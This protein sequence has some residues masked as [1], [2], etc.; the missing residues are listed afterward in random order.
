MTMRSVAELIHLNQLWEHTRRVG[1]TLKIHR[2]QPI[3][4]GIDDKFVVSVHDTTGANVIEV[5]TTNLESAATLI[6]DRNVIPNA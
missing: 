5:R 4:N 1:Y 3:S 6:L 2:W